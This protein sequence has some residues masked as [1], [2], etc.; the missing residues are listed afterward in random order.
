[1]MKKIFALRKAPVKF[2]SII[3]QKTQVK[4]EQNI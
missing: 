1:M 4:D 2:A 3:K